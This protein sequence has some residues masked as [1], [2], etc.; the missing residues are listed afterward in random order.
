MDVLWVHGQ[1]LGVLRGDGVPEVEWLDLAGLIGSD[2]AAKLRNGTTT[3][4]GLGGKKIGDAGVAVLA[5]VLPE[6]A[7]LKELYL[8]W[9]GIGE[10]GAVALSAVLPQC[11]ALKEL[12]L[13]SNQIGS[14]VRS[15]LSNMSNTVRNTNG[16]TITILQ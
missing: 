6:C 1:G 16:N 7:A 9:N 4:F 13:S 2:A 5:K 12:Y 15:K 14:S 3:R 10:A 8:E 11:A